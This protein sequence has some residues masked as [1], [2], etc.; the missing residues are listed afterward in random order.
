[1]EIQYQDLMDNQYQDLMVN[2]DRL[3]NGMTLV[4]LMTASHREQ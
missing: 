2:Q 4:A 3:R 1:M